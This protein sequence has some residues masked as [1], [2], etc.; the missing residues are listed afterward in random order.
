MLEEIKRKEVDKRDKQLPQSFE[1]LIQMYDL[2]RLWSYMGKMTEYINNIYPVGS[3]Y[4]SINNTDPASLFGGTWE[5]IKDT[6][7][8]SAGDTYQAGSTG[9]NSVHR[10]D[11]KIGNIMNYYEIIADNYSGNNQ[12]A[13]S[14]S[15]NKYSKSYGSENSINITY[16]SGHNQSIS[17]NTVNESTRYSIGDTDTASSLPPYLAVYVW[18]RIS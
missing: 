12:G 16:N 6:F 10:H 7:L 5:Q 11:F 1:Q 9:G 3:V 4:I 2:D 13:Y 8:L 18:K 15:E 14:Y 17:S